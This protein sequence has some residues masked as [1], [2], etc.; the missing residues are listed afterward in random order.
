MGGDVHDVLLRDPRTLAVLV[1]DV[2]GKG[3]AGALLAAMFQG[4]VRAA[5]GRGDDPA[6][7]LGAAAAQLCEGLER[8]GR[9]LTAVISEIDLV[10]GRVRYADAGHGHHLLLGP[11]GA[12]P[13]SAGG[14]P[15]GFLADPRY[16][17]GEA[18]LPPGGRLALFTDGLV[19]GGE[20]D[21]PPGARERLAAAVAAGARAAGL[22]AGAP[23]DDDRTIVI[24]RRET[25]WRS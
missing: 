24:V 9:F 23:D 4:A 7:A 14:P 6:A 12:Q 25:P 11:G 19:E 20:D 17:L 2:S 10:T 5:L 15:A 18:E 3:V 16:A 13:L 21:D 8:A 22:V 1:A